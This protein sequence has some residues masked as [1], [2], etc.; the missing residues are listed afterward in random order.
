MPAEPWLAP[1][2]EDL[3]LDATFARF[4]ADGFVRIPAVAT[5]EAVEALRT[6]ADDLLLGRVDHRPFFYQRDADNGVWDDAPLGV[7]WTGPTPEYRK[8]EKLERDPVFLRWL[9]NP[10][11]GRLA[12]HAAA[13]AGFPEAARGSGLPI[14]RAI[15]MNKA[16]RDPE[17]GAGGGTD[18]PWHQDGGQL[19]GLTRDPLIQ[20]WTALDEATEASGA[21]RFAVGSHRDGLAS[22]LGG[23][24]PVPLVAERTGPG[25]ASP[26]YEVVSMPARAGDVVML[27]NL[28]WHA[29]GR[30]ATTAPRRA[31][32]VCF[33]DPENGCARTRKTPRVFPRAFGV[34]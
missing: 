11:F 25:D 8:L 31:F 20:F 33:L 21:M 18:L 9:L 23:V 28:V 16:P 30:N 24:V 22:R 15:L 10:L 6:R 17:T 4:E 2:W 13:R 14:Y 12:C 34:Q 19:W 29:S 27:H 3:D 5:A 1:G 32:S 26:G 7:G